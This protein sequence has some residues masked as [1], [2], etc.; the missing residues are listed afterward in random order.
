MVTKR[1]TKVDDDVRAL[2]GTC[3]LTA[4]VAP[5]MDEVLALETAGPCSPVDSGEL[6]DSGGSSS[7]V[8]LT[9]LLPRLHLA[10]FRHSIPA[11]A[12]RLLP[13]CCRLDLGLREGVEIPPSPKPAGGHVVR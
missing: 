6:A 3:T 7:R 9:G 12:D 10:Q 1:L 5:A 13:R 2:L 4:T 8:A 11:V